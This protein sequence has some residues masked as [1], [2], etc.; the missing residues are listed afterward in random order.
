[1]IA[2]MI[3]TNIVTRFGGPESTYISFF[4]TIAIVNKMS[5]CPPLADL[6]GIE[7]IAGNLSFHKLIT[8]VS[9]GAMVVC[10]IVCGSL[11]FAHLCRYS[12][13]RKQKQLIRIIWTPAVFAIFSFFGVLNYN[14]ANYLLPVAELYE[15]LALIAVF[16]LLIAYVAPPTFSGQL[17][18][19]AG[20][21]DSQWFRNTWIVV[22]QV[23]PTRILTFIVNEVVEATHCHSTKSYHRAHTIVAVIQGILTVLCLMG[24]MRFY[25]KFRSQIHSA[26]PHIVVKLGIFKLIIVIEILQK[27]VFNALSQHNALKATTY[28]SYDDLNLGLFPLLVC[29]QSFIFSFLFIWPFWPRNEV[30]GSLPRAAFF[31]ALCDSLNIAD[32]IT[33]VF[34]AFQLLKGTYPTTPGVQQVWN[35]SDTHSGRRHTQISEDSKYS[36]GNNTM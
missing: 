28:L 16:Y 5:N 19:F 12:D 21:G 9:A 17:H 13:S 35:V 11:A 4:T 25:L 2:R 30:F 18:Y 34:R 29:F 32:I 7:P 26:D 3:S 10:C 36:M 24:L 23:L 6:R 22:V 1:M 20:N 27:I 8:Y 31:S 14:I 15:C 33:G